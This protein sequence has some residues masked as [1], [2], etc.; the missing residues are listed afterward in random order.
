MD[1]LHR[2]LV[3]ASATPAVAPAR[4]SLYPETEPFSF[5]WLPT[6]SA[7]EVYYEECGR[8][9]GRPCVILHGGPGGAINPTMR[10]FF[11]PARWRM[12][13]FDQR[14]C[15]RSRPNA[16]LTDNDTWALVEDLE[17]LR[18][19]T[20]AEKWTVFGGSWGS[21]L[22]LAYAVTYPERVE[23][24]ILRGVFLLTKAELAWFYQ[25]GAAMLYPD[26]WERFLAP[27]P[28]AEHGDLI[29]AY[30]GRTVRSGP[31][32]PMR[33]AAGRGTPSPSAA[34]TRVRPSSTRR[35]SRSPSHASRAT[36]SSTAASSRTTAGCWIRRGGWPT[37]RAGSC[38]AA[39][40]W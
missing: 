20:G 12:M 32:R 14:G 34:P 22:A 35:S 11:D 10:R 23:A 13:L 5:G 29:G 37:S 26:A 19:K 17:R 38:R 18:R 24:L 3:G 25:G 39:S 9:D 33:G 28:P 16:V 36:T 21:T 27:I 30:R 15:G 2:T 1:R 8:P 6:G 40:T 7:H 4:R 31:R